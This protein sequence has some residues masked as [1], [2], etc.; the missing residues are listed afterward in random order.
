MGTSWTSA[1]EMVVRVA[2][3]DD[4]EAIL[5]IYGPIVSDTVISFEEEVP[6]EGEIRARIE[7]SHVWLVAEVAGQVAGYAYASRFHPRA[8]YRW[9]VEVSIYL[10]D[11][12]RG[13]GLGRTLLAE[14]LERLTERGFVNA[15]AGTTLPNP[16][17]V[18]L[19]ESFGFTKIAHQKGVGFKLGAWHDVGWWQIQLRPPEP[20]PVLVD[21][22][23]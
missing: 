17:S 11:G 18:K 5:A 14:L 16:A 13:V 8:A 4:A 22:R 2:R 7:A 12:H 1:H 23:E 20:P 9:S 6:T 15:F 19:F 3:P 10:A 21:R